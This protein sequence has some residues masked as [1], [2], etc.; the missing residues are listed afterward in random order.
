[1]Q[2]ATQ[3]YVNIAAY[4]FITIDDTVEKRPQFLDLCNKLGL[5]GTILLTPEGINLFPAG[6]REP[7]D[8]FLSWLRS[9]DRF[10]DIIV[11]DNLQ[12]STNQPKDAWYRLEHRDELLQP[13]KHEIEIRFWDW[14]RIWRAYDKW[15]YPDDPDRDEP[16]FWLRVKL[17]HPTPKDLALVARKAEEK[18]RSNAGGSGKQT[19]PLQ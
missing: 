8:Q 1:M 7:I 18:A 6:L 14:K 17:W 5:K 12:G 10:A 15:P 4:K 2:P 13:G 11:D 19:I 9:D 16:F 3:P